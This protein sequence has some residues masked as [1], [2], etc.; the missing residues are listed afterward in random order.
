[1]N[2]PVLL[3]FAGLILCCLNGHPSINRE[4]ITGDTL[5][6][7]KPDDSLILL[8]RRGKFTL[9]KELGYSVSLN[10]LF[11]INWLHE[12]NAGQVNLLQCLSFRS[13]LDN[14]LNFSLSNSLVHNLGI[15]YY[16]DSISKFYP[17]DNTLTTRIE[18]NLK[19]ILTFN[20]NSAL[21]S[22]A[23]P[24]YDYYVTDSGKSV[25][26]LNSSFLTPLI[27]NLSIGF[28]IKWND[29]G[30]VNLG[31]SSAK[32]TYVR[33]TR[34]FD[35]RKITDFYGVAKGK[36][37]LFEY[38]LS[39]QLLV[40]RDLLTWFHWDCDL[41]VFKNYTASV[42]VNLKNLFG[43]KINKFLKTTIQTRIFYEEK[44]CKNLQLENLVAI[45]FYINL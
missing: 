42:D 36:N 25:K 26:L 17:D 1:V 32:L 7:E 34:I 24:G 2:L 22:R 23:M 21:L 16:F 30:S 14:N 33:D 3:S 4:S 28:G 31:I 13:V 20:I 12:K 9:K 44:V 40:N 5:R 11:F 45:G 18:L 15:Q 37:H 10:S 38:G 41:S 6:K 39:M 19:G 27:W 35:L 8:N 43:I 29:W